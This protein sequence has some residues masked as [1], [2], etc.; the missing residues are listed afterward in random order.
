M[1]RVLAIAFASLFLMAAS[2]DPT[3]Y[4]ADPA[5]EARAKALFEEIRCVV[6]QNESIAGSEA[7]IAHDVRTLVRE[8]IDAGASDKEVRQYLLGRYGEFILLRPRLSVRNAILWGAPFAIVLIGVALI[9][10]RRP[11]S[12]AV[13]GTEEDLTPQELE[14]LKQMQER[15]TPS[16]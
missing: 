15:R 12:L 7:D 3:E 13:N 4:L 11:R 10:R 14:A 8:Q 5:K 1:R 16:S 9:L 2:D 6:C